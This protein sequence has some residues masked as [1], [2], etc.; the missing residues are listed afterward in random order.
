M[1][2]TEAC[3]DADAVNRRV[4]LS[5]ILIDNEFAVSALFAFL[6]D[7]GLLDKIQVFISNP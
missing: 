2:S 4:H 6:T 3:F 1:A 5:R 7:T